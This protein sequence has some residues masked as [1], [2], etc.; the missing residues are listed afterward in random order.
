[1][2]AQTP[3]ARTPPPLRARTPQMLTP[4]R[5]APDGPVAATWACSPSRFTDPGSV[6]SVPAWA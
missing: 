5:L 1:M 3:A 4:P 2:R 6:G